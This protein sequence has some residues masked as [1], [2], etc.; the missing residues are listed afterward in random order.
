MKTRDE[1]TIYLED[2]P[3]EEALMDCLSF[4]RQRPKPYERLKTAE[5]IGRVTA[6]PVYAGVSN[7]HYHASAMDGIAVEAGKTKNAHESRPMTLKEGTDFVYVD[8]GHAIPSPFDAVIMI[9]HVNERAQDTLDIIE[10]AVPWQHIR[11]IGED[12]T[13][14]EMILPQGHQIRPVDAG[15]L[16]GAQVLEVDVIKKPEVA[17]YPSGNELI[18]P[19]ERAEP[20]KLIEFNG[21]IF[22][23]LVASWGGVPELHEIVKDDRAMIRQA[24]ITGT[25]EADLVLLNAGSS[26]GSRDYTKDVIEELGEVWTHGIATRPGKPV[27]IGCVNNTIVIGVPGYPVSAHFVMEWF[28][29][30][31]LYEWQGLQVPEK[32][33]MP[34]IA[35]RRMTSNMGSEDFVRVHIGKVNGQY[36]ANPLSRSASVTMSLV[37]ADGIVTIP[38]GHLGVEQGDEITARLL[39]P[40]SQLDQTILFSGSH[41]LSI[42][43]LSSVMKQHDGQSSVTPSHTG[44]LAGIMAI[45]RGDAH[46]AGIHL[47][48]P[49][50][51]TYND[52][53]IRKWLKGMTIVKLPFLKRKQGLIVPSGNPEQ[54]TGIRDIREKELHF[55]NRQKG[56]G[57]RVLFDH[58][59]KQENIQQDEIK[60]Y[61]REMF[62]HLSVAAEVMVDPKACGM[63]IY[64]AAQAVGADFVPVDDES[65]DVIMTEDFFNSDRGQKLFQALRSETFKEQVEALGGYTVDSDV[66]PVTIQI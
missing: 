50:S 49:A 56:A 47:L 7:P 12:I 26:A 41:D 30:P 61:Q 40:K 15:A 32:P 19:D 9:E 53:D 10:P 35:G 52:P 42:D 36:I 11:P 64:S 31:I 38:P 34:V 3:R 46:V 24:L 21:T 27:I 60:G 14:G 51:G 23:G 55:V 66:E 2:K 45:R 1:R 39:K 58:L 20:G 4:I 59:L 63:G 6:K 13:Y 48:D 5:A 65:Y 54:V 25:E 37:K 18:Q 29:E 44:S 22:A 33:E 57:T 28:V 17:I 16:L 43:I 8:T 62:T